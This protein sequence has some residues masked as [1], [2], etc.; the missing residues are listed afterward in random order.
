MLSRM[1]HEAQRGSVE[2][3]NR[4][5]MQME[6]P[7]RK[8][9][10]QE[11]SPL[12]RPKIGDSDLVQESLLDASRSF[13]RFQG[14]TADE[15]TAW[16]RQI[17]LNNLSHHRRSYLGTE[18]RD[19]LREEPWPRADSDSDT[20]S[21]IAGNLTEPHEEVSASEEYQLV[22]AALKR[23]PEEFQQV[24]RWRFQN[25]HTVAQ[26]AEKLNRSLSSTKKLLARAAQHFD[27]ELNRDGQSA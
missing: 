2:S 12:L 23:L 26:I 25:G 27:R 14:T 11:N 19:V 3:L 10:E 1:I 9:A 18:K 24:L 17:L 4:L 15:L 13:G 21:V 16:M 7:L 8:M 6:R 20:G 5:L 22:Q